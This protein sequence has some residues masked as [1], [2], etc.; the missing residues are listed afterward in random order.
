GLTATP[1]RG[2]G[3]GLGNLYDLIVECPSVAEL[4]EMGHL[5]PTRVFAPDRPD[6]TGAR[7]ERGE[8][9]ER[10][11]A[12]RMDTPEPVGHVV[13]HWLEW[14]ER[15]R[16]VVF[17]TGVKHSINLRDGFRRAGVAAEHIDGNTPTEE[18]DRILARLARGEVDLVTNAMVLTEG[19]DSPAVGCLILA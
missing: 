17:A 6:L 19:W 14:A 5:V 12:E 2:D 15:R 8:Y 10:Q 4:I 9:V 18:R 3:R 7:V 16:T 11:L 13:P 1:C